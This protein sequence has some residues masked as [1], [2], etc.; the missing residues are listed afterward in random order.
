MTDHYP[1]LQYQFHVQ[2]EGITVAHFTEVGGLSMERE[3]KEVPQGGMNDHV[4]VLP[5]RLKY[6][7]I[8]LKRGLTHS[9]EL[10]L[11]FQRGVYD[12][13]V[14]RRHVSLYQ[15]DKNGA[16]VRHWEIN[17]AFPVKYAISDFNSAN[18]TAMV[19]TLVLAHD[20]LS[21]SKS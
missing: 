4:H 14:Q 21:L 1:L 19:E 11:W 12:L 7:D 8:T 5:G 13:E 15:M 17:N 2:I 9:Y 3:R 18:N 16:T 6:A 10:W 20:G